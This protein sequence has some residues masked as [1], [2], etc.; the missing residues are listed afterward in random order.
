MT[1]RPFEDQPARDQIRDAL[2]QNLLVE[3]G[4]GSGKTTCLVERM[5]SL[6][7]DG[8]PVER[9][10]AVTFTRKA[11]GELRERF[12]LELERALRASTEESER[13]RLDL[14]LRRLD[15]A[16]LGTIHAFCGR[17]L[18][19]RALEAGL[20]PTFEELDEEPFAAL[21]EE[22]FREWLERCRLSEHPSPM[23]LT[24]SDIFPSRSPKLRLWNGI[25]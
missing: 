16:F 22:F 19:E 21:R 10:A 17:L 6:V 7:R 4:A 5:L 9:I 13:S 3:A 8:E 23:A 20:D 15:E 11:A 24:R 1:T 12:Q 14:A 18:R 2:V 25:R